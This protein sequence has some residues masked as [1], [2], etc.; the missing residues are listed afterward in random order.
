[1]RDVIGHPRLQ[2]PPL[3]QRLRFPLPSRLRP[4]IPGRKRGRREDCNPSFQRDTLHFLP[5]YNP[6]SRS[7]LYFHADATFSLVK[8]SASA[9]TKKGKEEEE[10][11]IE[12]LPG[13]TGRVRDANF[14]AGFQ[15]F[16]PALPSSA[17]VPLA[18]LKR[19]TRLFR[20]IVPPPCF[21]L[22][23]EIAFLL[24]PFIADA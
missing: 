11:E 21:I 15:R 2:R 18:Y 6:P 14:F 8:S 13:S 4:S 5:M 24:P 22:G 3:L 19:N 16:P 7:P 1:M 9:K 23:W 10:G 12:T 17:L 20:E